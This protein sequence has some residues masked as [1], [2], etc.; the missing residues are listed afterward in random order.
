LCAQHLWK[1]FNNWNFKI[2]IFNGAYLTQQI[3]LKINFRIVWIFFFVYL[4]MDNLVLDI[5]NDLFKNLKK[6]SALELLQM[7]LG[8]WSNV[9]FSNFFL[10]LQ[11]RNDLNN[12]VIR[13]HIPLN[14]G[15][16][17]WSLCKEFNPHK[18]QMRL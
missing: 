9:V 16:L 1:V 3:K 13:L 12:S 10:C 5:I 8:V 4:T 2:N 6:C 17:S 15:L 11:T 14:E 18:S 7:S